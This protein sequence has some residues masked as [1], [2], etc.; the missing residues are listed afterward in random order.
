MDKISLFGTVIVFIGFASLAAAGLI[1]AT[2]V[3]IKRGLRSKFYTA[4]LLLCMLGMLMLAGTKP[5]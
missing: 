1:P 2:S 3:P 5:I 4:G